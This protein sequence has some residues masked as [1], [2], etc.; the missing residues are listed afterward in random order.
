MRK[1]KLLLVL[2]LVI[3]VVF[4][5]SVAFA[6]SDN[7]QQGNTNQNQEQNQGED[8][9]NQEQ[10]QEQNQ[11][12]AC[13]NKCGDGVCQ[14]IVCLAMGCPCA[15]NEQNCSK[16]CKNDDE[17][18]NK[19]S[20]SANGELHRSV[21]ANFV[22]GLLNVASRSE[23]GIGEQVRVIAQEQNQ[24]KEK[25]A[26]QIEAIEKRNKFK[27]FLI[28]TDYKNVGAL[29]SEMVQTRNQLEQLNR[30]MEQT[31]NTADKTELQNQITAL[32]E[33]QI[34]IETLLKKAEGKF[35]LFGWLVKLFNKD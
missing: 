23:G 34:Q 4:G 3:A 32:E 12:S 26:D 28:G 19:A 2:F 27:T 18:G 16:D 25:I 7:S 6:K 22:Q 20:V 29:R 9:Q 31:K 24:N 5:F 35:S 11:N 8:I 10:E 1:I 15:E 21:V 17:N 14:E 33:E 13:E 30:L